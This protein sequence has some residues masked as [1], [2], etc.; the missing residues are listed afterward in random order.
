MI[1]RAL[2]LGLLLATPAQAVQI[3]DL[4]L[5]CGGR[6]VRGVI[7]SVACGGGGLWL[8]ALATGFPVAEAPVVRFALT[9]DGVLIGEETRTLPTDLGPIL[10]AG[11][12]TG[13]GLPH[14][15]GLGMG[16]ALPLPCGA[17]CTGSAV[18]SI[19]LV[20][21]SDPEVAFE[22]DVPTPEPTTLLLVGSSFTVLGWWLRRRGG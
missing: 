17:G 6:E 8:D 18:A 4:R 14:Y 15:T 5:L 16:W 3:T 13:S 9:L 2:L 20:G 21:G 10:Q 1:G 7:T 11:N 19:G 12:P 22:L